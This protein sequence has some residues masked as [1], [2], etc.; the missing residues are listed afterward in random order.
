MACPRTV[1]GLLA[2]TAV[3]TAT[4]A[5]A[6]TPGMVPGMGSTTSTTD[7]YINNQQNA[8]TAAPATPDCDSMVSYLDS[9]VPQSQVR[10]FF[11]ANYEDRRPTRNEYFFP[12]SGAPGYPG[13]WTPE[14]KVDWQQ[15][16]SYIEYAFIPQLSGFLQLATRWV[17]PDINDN[18]YGLGDVNAGLKYAFIET[19]GLALTG[20]L[21]LTIPSRSGPGLSTDHYS[22]EPA[23]LFY[24]RPITWLALE[25]QLKYWVP[26]D[27]SDFSGQLLDY[28]L[29]VSF[30]ERS[31]TDFWFAPI[32]EVEAWTILSGQEMEVFPDGQGVAHGSAGETICNAMVGVRF[33]FGDNGDI[34]V[35]GGH[36]LTGDAWAQYFWRVEF[37]I[38]F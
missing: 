9:S 31:Y 36:S 33:G 2:V 1:L 4:A 24:L 10:I 38:R 23:F 6:Q 18:A 21:R 29:G 28:G 27:G 22:I 19:G 12:K 8:Q 37:R 34:Y 35:G 17:N 3:L 26:L 15:L 25:G 5:Q 20:Q 14:Q 7:Q 30:G 16:N 13:W 32:I 11:D